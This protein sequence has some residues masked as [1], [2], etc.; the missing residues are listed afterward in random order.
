MWKSTSSRL[1][2]FLQRLT[3]CQASR[4]NHPARGVFVMIT[5][6]P[7]K[8]EKAFRKN[9]SYCR[10]IS[11]HRS[12]ESRAWLLIYDTLIHHWLDK[13]FHV[14]SPT[15]YPPLQGHANCHDT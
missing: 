1:N 8:V 10:K 3:I 6:S 13:I 4:P 11:R 14:E 2:V 5:I 15:P 7:Q 9:Y 12:N